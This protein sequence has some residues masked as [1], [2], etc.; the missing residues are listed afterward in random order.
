[1]TAEKNDELQLQIQY[2]LMEQL[3]STS[4][5]QNKFY[6]ML[7]ECVFE[8]DNEGYFSFTNDVW[9]TKL[10]YKHQELKYAKLDKLLHG[11][12]KKNILSRIEI[13]LASN[14]PTY[15][16]EVQLEAKSGHLHTFIMKLSKTDDV[17]TGILGVL[18]DISERKELEIKLRQ[19]ETEFKRL[20]YVAMHTSNLVIITNRD[21]GITWVNTSFESLTGYSLEEIIYK[22]PGDILQGPNSSDETI[23]QM[24]EA[25]SNRQRFNVEIVNY[26]KSGAAYWVQIDGSPVFDE[27]G[28][29]EGFIAIQNDITSSVR[30]K[31]ALQLS[32]LNYRTVV[33][34]ISEAIVKMDLQGHLQ[35]AN[36]AWFKL[37]E[38]QEHH[39][40][41][42]RI[43]DYL[44]TE[45][46]E[47]LHAVLNTYD[48][49]NASEVKKLELQIKTDTRTHWVE[50]STVPVRNESGELIT[51][52]ATLINIDERIMT[53]AY[54]EKSKEEAETLAHAK[55][56]FM[57]NISHEIRTPLNAIIG[58]SD[59]LNCTE[60]TPE[61][62]RY[63]EMVHTS[64]DALLA[65]L[66][67]ILT[68]TKNE[69]ST[70]ELESYPFQL[71]QCLEDVIDITGQQALNKNIALILDIGSEA[72]LHVNSDKLRLRQVMLN[73]VSNAIKFTEE[74]T[75]TV[76]AHSTIV[77]TDR[78]DVYITVNDTG[79]GI[80]QS[81]Q[82]ELFEPFIQQDV[83][84]TRRYGG[85]GLGLAIC[86]QIVETA[87]GEI[88]LESKV[89]MGTTFTIRWPMQISP[90][91]K[92]IEHDHIVWVVAED[93]LLS[94]AIIHAL[95]RLGF[96][97]CV[98]KKLVELEEGTHD[99]TLLI[100]ALN[101]DDNR[102]CLQLGVSSSINIIRLNVDSEKKTFSLTN[103]NDIEI[104]GPFKPSN[105]A[106]AL[107][108]SSL[109]E[110]ISFDIKKKSNQPETYY[111]FSDKRIL[112]VE[113]NETNA[114]LAKRIL[115]NAG[116]A[117]EYAEHGEEA[118]VKIQTDQY[119]LV[120]MDI[121]MPVMDGVTA[122]TKIRSLPE[123]FS[124]IPIIA[125]TADA[126]HGDKERFTQVGMNDYLAKPL[127]I[128]T[129]LETVSRNLNAN[130]H[131]VTEKKLQRIKHSMNLVKEYLNSPDL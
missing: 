78:A 93:P 66:D 67:D 28:V 82:E 85:S 37:L 19:R 114:I 77:D 111:D 106:F 69:Y 46:S 115:E 36:D 124:N 1:M 43:Y 104:N 16:D 101:D 62:T 58:M 108:Q 68:Y 50:L 48:E 60:L 76:T 95:N 7:G 97:N 23:K 92:E 86:K 105:L 47:K 4:N 14:N 40:H 45:D 20:S 49:D 91:M 22:K 56:R 79:I 17:N 117:T 89:G 128:E 120:L 81:K 44:T 126:L 6:E 83:S 84:I 2:A 129:L 88:Y 52:A 119:D 57:A 32:E 121:Q 63:V 42:A 25:I 10:G 87:G 123:K 94:Q 8:L 118:L 109:A 13:W 30:T 27:Q 107:S 103:P 31:Q 35:F 127:R 53:E 74:G 65:I 130:Q 55:S 125:L 98:C 113:D 26:K 99:C 102:R 12:D 9:Q 100:D 15:K 64:G 3:S 96:T 59:L 80:P 122:T 24:S 73:L 110:L 70:L 21:G 131:S 33:D 38:R 112:I 41:K 34:N 39:L 75:I 18:F 90:M 51:I 11:V 71:D 61:Q 5:K 72:E 54:L 116:A 29:F